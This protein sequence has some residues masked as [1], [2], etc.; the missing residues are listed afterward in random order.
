[1]CMTSVVLVDFGIRSGVNVY[2]FVK[3]ILLVAPSYQRF[4]EV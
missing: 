1:M 3:V 2:Q 4:M